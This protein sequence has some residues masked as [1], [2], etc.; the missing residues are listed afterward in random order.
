[1]IFYFKQRV[2]ISPIKRIL[3]ALLAYAVWGGSMP[4]AHADLGNLNLVMRATLVS[5]ACAVSIDSSNQTVRLGTWATRQFVA[6]PKVAPP[7]RFVINLEDC[8]QVASG[9]RV[10]FNGVPS[11]KDNTLFSLNSGSAATGV[12]VAVL[13]RN[14][15]RITPKKLSIVYPLSSSSTKFA[16]VFYAQY[17]AFQGVTVTAGSANADVTFS[18]SYL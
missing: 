11:V 9:V 8:G 4:I 2:T 7:V 13:D 10:Q 12:G 18:M 1:M 15:N 5:N 14:G 17:V 16:L 6:T 3:Y